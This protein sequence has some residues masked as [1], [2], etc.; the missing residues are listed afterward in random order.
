VLADIDA[1]A[2]AAARRTAVYNE[3]Q[4]LVTVYESDVLEDIPQSEQW[5]LVI[6]NPPHF[7]SDPDRPDNVKVVDPDWQLHERFYASAKSYMRSGGLVVMSENSAA[8]DPDV[9]ADMIRRG[10]GS[11]VAVHPGTDIHGE[12]NGLYYQ[13]SEW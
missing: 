8:T 9:F 6:G 12:P 10:G 1:T 13:V 4:D 2:V 7:L 3:L 11:P 5:D